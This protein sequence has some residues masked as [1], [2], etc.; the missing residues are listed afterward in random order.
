[1]KRA[2]REIMVGDVIGISPDASLRDAIKKMR[3][4]RITSLLVERRVP[5][6]TWGVIT[7][8]DIVHKV[9]GQNRDVDSLKVSDVMTRP[10]TTVKP[11]STI[12][13]CA[14]L[15]QRDGIRRVFVFDGKDIVGIISIS[16]IF[17]A[18]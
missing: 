5:S 10:I 4:H 6:S 14:A 9:I 3:E 7:Q 16:N 11:E 13:D 8:T 15:M 12:L 1:M 17:K 18:I 2:A